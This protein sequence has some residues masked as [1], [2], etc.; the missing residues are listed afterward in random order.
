MEAGSGEI[1]ERYGPSLPF[2]NRLTKVPCRPAGFGTPL[3][4]SR[5]S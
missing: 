2:E 3:Q 1:S 4:N 5:R